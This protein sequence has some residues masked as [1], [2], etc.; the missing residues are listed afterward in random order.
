MRGFW[1]HAS[2]VCAAGIA[3]IALASPAS[4]ASNCASKLPGNQSSCSIQY[5]ENL[6]GAFGNTDPA[7]YTGPGTHFE[8]TFTFTTSLARKI[9]IDLSSSY[10]AHLGESNMFDWNV[11]FMSKGVTINGTVVPVTRTGMDEGRY[12]ANFRLP[13]GLNSILVKGSSGENGS[14][15]GIFTLSGVP[16]TSTWA[17]MVLGVGFAGVAMRSRRRSLSCD[18]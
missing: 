11:N 10:A 16:E 14:Y 9:T 15:A 6:S 1:A 18:S 8:D 7:L 4:A 13:A 5:I 17:M 2:A 3:T 12:L